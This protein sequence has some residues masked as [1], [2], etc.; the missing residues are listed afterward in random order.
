MCKLGKSSK[1]EAN[2]RVYA[3]A[4]NTDGKE[5][6]VFLIPRANVLGVGVSAINMDEAVELS[7]SLLR[8]N[9]RGYI[10]VTGVHGI[11]EAQSD[12]EFRAILNSSFITTPDGMP[13]V[14]VG[15]L[16]GFSEM[17]R[18]FGPDYMM[19]FC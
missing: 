9:G 19:E 17:R 10:C 8:E 16:Q 5:A 14:W 18:V 12:P 15:R 3:A 2:E 6:A 13:T 11:I 7:D 1:V 4:E